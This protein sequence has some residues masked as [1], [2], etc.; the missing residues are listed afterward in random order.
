MYAKVVSN[1]PGRPADLSQIDRDIR[2]GLIYDR[3][4]RDSAEVNR[5]FFD[6]KFDEFPTRS[7][8][9]PGKRNDFRRASRLMRRIIHVLT[10]N[11]YKRDPLRTLDAGEEATDFLNR[12]YKRL[13]MS[14]KWA[15]ADQFSLVGDACAFQWSGSTDPD[16]P[17]KVT[18]WPA[19]EFTVWLDPDDPL[20]PKAV[21][22][23]DKFDCSRRLRVYTEESIAEYTT[24]KLE[25]GQ[26]S[27]GTAWN[28][29]PVRPTD[30]VDEK[31]RGFIP[32]T[33]VH[34]EAPVT[35]F[36]TEGLGDFLRQANDHV[37]FRLDRLGDSIRFIVKP[38]GVATGVDDDW[39]A[40]VDPQPGTFI[41][42]AA[43]VANAGENGAATN[44]SLA[45]LTPDLGYIG[46][47]WDDLNAFID[48]VLECCGIPPGA[49][50]MTG[51][52]TS[53]VAL[54]IEAAPIL[55]WAEAR[56]KPFADFEE[57]AAR[58]A[59]RV[60]AC[61]IRKG[62]VEP[63]DWLDAVAVDGGLGLEWASLYI[64][65]PGQER[66]RADQF[67]LSMGLTSKLR[68][69]MDR[70]TLTRSQAMARLAQVEKDNADLVAIGVDPGVPDATVDGTE[71]GG[72]EEEL[73]PGSAGG[74]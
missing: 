73:D 46:A 26:T 16:Y 59:F 13:G 17:V 55:A 62:N 66:D 39:T 53:G 37:N 3:E 28:A 2:A 22:T 5:K 7:D 36:W 57:A 14:S 32:F 45:Y 30:Y 35:D 10:G 42:L 4:R 40:P 41:T 58:M 31:G 25:P 52:A 71:A 38:I 21:A 23:I 50:R 54:L 29:G 19:D 12:L 44:P 6:G 51:N 47:D 65:L 60:A 49:I 24:D 72:G 20:T 68:M 63:Q 69:L 18:V 27:G 48:H 8:N 34:A 56:Q 70:Y 43:F 74:I 67:E 33:F 11:L 1:K 64:Q 9:A 15:K 61:W